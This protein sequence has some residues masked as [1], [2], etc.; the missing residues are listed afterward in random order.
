MK[1][2][3]RDLPT[4]KVG[5]FCGLIQ[6]M[7][8]VGLGELSHAGLTLDRGLVE[9]IN[10]KLGQLNDKVSKVTDSSHSGTCAGRASCG[11]LM[12]NLF[13]FWT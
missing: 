12:E 7:R 4:R 9:L 13:K 11:I 8:Q 3:W 2:P 5:A 10:L 1:F 6:M